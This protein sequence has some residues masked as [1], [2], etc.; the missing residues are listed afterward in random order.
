[1]KISILGPGR[2]GSF[3]AWYMNKIGNE[4][5]LWGRESSEQIKNFIETRQNEYVTMPDAVDITTNLQKAI[6]SS[7]FIIIS[8]S[9]Q[10]LRNLM[11]KIKEINDFDT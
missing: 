10:G 5:I 7:D 6:K 9:A 2:W 8:I 3:I 11:S 4:T 1:M